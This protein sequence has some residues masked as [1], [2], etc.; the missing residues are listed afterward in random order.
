MSKTDFFTEEM[1]QRYDERNASLAP[2]SNAMHF[3]IQL[4]LK[5]LPAR[6]RVLCVGAG[7]GAEILSLSTVFPQW[8]FVA[9]EPSLAML[10]VCRG[11]V[12]AAGLAG[13]CEFVH[14]YIHDVPARGDFDAVLSVLVGHFVARDERVGYFRNAASHLKSGG[15]FVNTEISSDL[16]SPE[17]PAMLK[18]WEKVQSLMGA[19]A[20]S[21]TMLPKQL[22]EMLTVLPPVEVEALLRKAGFASPVQFFRAFM[23]CG[24]YG[25]KG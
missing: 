15:Y 8:S 5:D 23:I 12:E 7:T 16:D 6:S 9:V 10:T 19:T 25:V 20:E 4:V 17:F 2:I 14:G 24:W 13:R 22:R 3:L 21:L 1:A 11:R 18:N